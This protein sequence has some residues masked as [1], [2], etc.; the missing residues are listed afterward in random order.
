M[1]YTCPPQQ[2]ISE[3][4]TFDNI[5]GLQV[6]QGGGLTQGNFE[7]ITTVTEKDNRFFDTGTFSLP[8]TLDKLQITDTVQAAKINSVNFKIYPNFDETNVLNFVAYGPLTKRFSAAVI[9]I[10][11]HFP[12][13]IESN[14]IRANY[15]TGN[16]AFNISYNSEEDFT[17][18]QFDASTLGNPFYIDYSRNSSVNISSL[19]FEISKYR[20]F[21]S[22]YS[23]YIL[24]TS[25]GSYSVVDMTGTT[26]LT[27]GTLSV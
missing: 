18:V 8:Y 6:I 13:A 2:R 15:S 14:R 17:F 5:V 21:S 24:E 22:Y 12:A 26:S 1:S 3:G 10:I 4:T 16:T 7:F 20:D 11:N 27:A 25:N 23:S 9:N 19:E